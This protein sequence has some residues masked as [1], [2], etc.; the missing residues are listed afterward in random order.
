VE[1]GKRLD[2][3]RDLVRIFSSDVPALPIYYDLDAVPVGY[4]LT[5]VQ[6]LQ[7]IAHTGVIMHTWNAHE[8]DLQT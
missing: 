2:M 7:G 6:P 5:G 3:E 4:G 8:W 1:E